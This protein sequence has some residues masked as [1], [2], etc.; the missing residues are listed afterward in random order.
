MSFCFP[1]PD[2]NVSIV[3]GAGMLAAFLTFIT[4]GLALGP[5]RRNRGK[6][7]AEQARLVFPV[8]VAARSNIWF[9]PAVLTLA[10]LLL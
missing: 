3:I 4:N 9:V 2:L 7:W 6:H 1:L 5:W 10:V 8:I